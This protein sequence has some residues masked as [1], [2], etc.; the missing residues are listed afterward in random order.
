MLFITGLFYFHFQD[1]IAAYS[2]I[3]F[4]VLLGIFWLYTLFRV[5]ETKGMTIEQI[6]QSFRVNS[7]GQ[8]QRISDNEDD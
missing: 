6:S 1:A 8:Y 5:P 7:V 2:F 4:V 3:P